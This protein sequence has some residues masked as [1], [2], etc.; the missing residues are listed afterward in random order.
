MAE[1][2]LDKRGFVV[3]SVQLRNDFADLYVAGAIEATKELK[4]EIE[5]LKH[6][7]K[8]SCIFK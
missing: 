5:T 7:K 3:L 6:N 2:Y 8:N 1:A 4:E